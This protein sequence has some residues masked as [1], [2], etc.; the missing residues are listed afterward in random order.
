MYTFDNPDKSTIGIYNWLQTAFLNPN[1]K[2][3][4]I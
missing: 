1:F 4:V 3:D 2:F